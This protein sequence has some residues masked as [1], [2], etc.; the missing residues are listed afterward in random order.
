MPE[1]SIMLTRIWLTWDSA[2]YWEFSRSGHRWIFRC[3]RRAG[4]S[5]REGN[6]LDWRRDFAPARENV[7]LCHLECR[8]RRNSWYPLW[9]VHVDQILFVNH[10]RKD[11]VIRTELFQNGEK[12]PRTIYHF[13]LSSTKKNEILIENREDQY[14]ERDDYG[15]SRHFDET[16]M[17]FPASKYVK[18]N[19]S[20]S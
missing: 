19:T 3:K 20:D 4:P 9:Y 10:L 14:I 7:A 15:L 5:R 2:Q 1:L 6:T 11:K 13:F 8:Q 17:N 18:T 16:R 12:Q